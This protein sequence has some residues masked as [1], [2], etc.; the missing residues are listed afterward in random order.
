MKAAAKAEGG[1]WPAASWV[2]EFSIHINNNRVTELNF[3]RIDLPGIVLC[4]QL[5]K[6]RRGY[7]GDATDLLE[8]SLKSSLLLLRA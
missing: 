3:G 6:K 2:S 5:E 8:V 7:V 1:W 4:V